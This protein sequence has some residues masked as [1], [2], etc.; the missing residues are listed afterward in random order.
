MASLGTWT[1][2]WR[3]V[4]I[5]AGLMY[6]KLPGSGSHPIHVCEPGFAVNN[7]QIETLTFRINA[8]QGFDQFDELLGIK[9]W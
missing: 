9:T 3:P 6:R 1:P 4:P 7:L 2:S 8:N 5:K